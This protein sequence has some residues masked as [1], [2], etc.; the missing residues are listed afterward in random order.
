MKR[1]LALFLAV[2][3]LAALLSGCGSKQ[4]EAPQPTAAPAL[5]TAKPADSPKATEAPK[6]TETPAPAQPIIV[7]DAIGREVE[8]PGRLSR[9]AAPYHSRL[10]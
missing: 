10:G 3:L 8:L 4:V 2:L 5:E 7:T 9:V 1:M 6:A